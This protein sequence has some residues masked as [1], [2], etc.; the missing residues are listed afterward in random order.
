MDARRTLLTAHFR[1][2]EFDSRDGALV[3]GAHEDSVRKWCEWIGE[4]LRARF[5]AV[6]ILSGYRSYARNELVGGAPYSVHLLRTPLPDRGLR[7]SAVAVAADVRC[8]RGSPASWALWFLDH[9]QAHPHLGRYH[10]G[11]LGI[12]DSFVHLD[13][14]PARRW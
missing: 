8:R 4:P 9:R 6:T 12:Y 5:G 11:G 14:G 10:R 13:T 2:S 3:P 1:L 7:S